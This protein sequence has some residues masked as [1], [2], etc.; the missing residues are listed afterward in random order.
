MIVGS[1]ISNKVFFTL[2]IATELIGAWCG[3][4]EIQASKPGFAIFACLFSVYV[5][6]RSTVVPPFLFFRSG[7]QRDTLCHGGLVNW[8]A[9]RKSIGLISFSISVALMGLLEIAANS[10]GWASRSTSFAMIV[11]WAAVS[12][13]GVAWI[14]MSVWVVRY[15]YSWFIIRQHKK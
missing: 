11:G 6:W 5:L 8:P 2:G 1:M 14:Y 15:F 13:F 4:I 9:L 10:H 3:W 12:A 7:T